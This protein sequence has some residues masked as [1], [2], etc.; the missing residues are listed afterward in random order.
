MKCSVINVH[1]NLCKEKNSQATVCGKKE[2]VGYK[3]KLAKH[4]GVV[5]SLEYST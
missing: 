4:N 2:F 1:A 3:T 5:F